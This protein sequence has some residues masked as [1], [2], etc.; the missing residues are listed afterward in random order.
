VVTNT[1]AD[2]FSR[3]LVPDENQMEPQVANYILNVG[4]SDED[5]ARMDYLA[6]RA[7][8]GSLSAEEREEAEN[9]NRVAHLLALLKSKARLAL[10]N[11]NGGESHE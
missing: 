8:G 11:G 7:R 3:V 1:E 5:H 6:S 9:F 2:I 10:R 4:F